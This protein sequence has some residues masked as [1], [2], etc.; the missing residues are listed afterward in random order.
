MPAIR[1]EALTKEF[2]VGFWRK[3]VHRALDQ[4][5]LSVEP[6]EVFGFLGPNGAG[7][8][9]TLKLLLQLIFPTSGVAEILGRP[10]GS[11]DVRHR[12]GY[13]PETPYFYDNLTA[14]E[15]LLYFAKLFGYAPAD[16]RRRV[17]RRARRRLRVQRL[18]R[19]VRHHPGHVHVPVAP[20]RRRDQFSRHVAVAARL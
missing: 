1:T 12:I 11:V 13:L 6:G 4:L 15:L 9:T 18:R 17:D 7:K 19:A 14:E 16:R 20:Q 3:R 10:A 2:P 5:T 8:T